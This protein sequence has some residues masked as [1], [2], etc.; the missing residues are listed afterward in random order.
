MYVKDIIKSVADIL[1]LTEIKDYLNE[2]NNAS[3]DENT[4]S[5]STDSSASSS[6]NESTEIVVPDTLNDLL[7]A[8]NITNN[9]LA[10]NYYE[11]LAKTN[12]VSSNSIIKFSKITDK[13]ILEIKSIED[14]NGTKIDFKIMSDG[15]HLSQDCSCVVEYSY[16]PDE[17]KFDDNID[18]Y[19][20]I[21]T[22]LFSYGVASEYLFLKGDIEDAYNWDL[23][24]KN[25]LFA[26]SRPKRS[27]YFPSKRWY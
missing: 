27:I 26:M 2:L 8:V 6:T 20:K 25:T 10:S 16:L 7:L 21:N 24:F 5:D 22:L 15:I 14:I 1:D 3:T 19:L 12:V 4:G 18:Y 23:K 11:L 13:N 9:N 17:V